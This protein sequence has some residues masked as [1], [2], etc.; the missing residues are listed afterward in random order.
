MLQVLEVLGVA[1]EM[2]LKDPAQTAIAPQEPRT[3]IY[4]EGKGA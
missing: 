1:G 2:R 4:A 3:R